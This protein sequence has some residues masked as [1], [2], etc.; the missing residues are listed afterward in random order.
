METDRVGAADG[1]WGLALLVPQ[2]RA[3][4]L[5]GHWLLARSSGVTRPFEGLELL[6]EVALQPGA[7]LALERAE[8]LDVR[9]QLVALL[10]QLT[11]HLLTTLGGLGVEHLGPRAGL[12][13]EP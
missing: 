4:A 9:V 7:V 6:G 11:E 12:C 10:L 3:E 8:V 13:L 1:G 5:G 2:D